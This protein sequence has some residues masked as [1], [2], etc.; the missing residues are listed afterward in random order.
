MGSSGGGGPSWKRKKME[1]E[2]QILGD[3]ASK[4][5]RYLIKDWRNSAGVICQHIG[6]SSTHP[7]TSSQLRIFLTNW[8]ERW[9]S[10]TATFSFNSSQLLL[11]LLCHINM[12]KRDGK[13]V[14]E[15]ETVIL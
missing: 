6:K 3:R 13:Y 2:D 8:E 11:L 14:Y 1:T 12:K 7:F 4:C 5:V 15:S 10:A 9:T